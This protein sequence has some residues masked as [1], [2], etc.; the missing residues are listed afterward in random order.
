[1]SP[2]DRWMNRVV[3]V[4]ML[5]AYLGMLFGGMVVSILSGVTVYTQ[6]GS[7]TAAFLAAVSVFAA[8]SAGQQLF[9][10]YCWK[11]F[12]VTQSPPDDGRTDPP[13]A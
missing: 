10:K 5:V 3:G 11:K 7:K 6:L 1:M 4:F 8:C 12:V 2:K 13:A 9:M